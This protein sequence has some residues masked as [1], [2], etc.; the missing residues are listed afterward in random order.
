MVTIYDIAKKANVSPMTV[1]RV[2]NNSGKISEKTRE[3]VE[4]IIKELNYIPNNAARS[5]TL[6]QSKILSLLITDITN[7]FYTKVARGAEDKAKQMGYRLL[8]SNSDESL[9]KESEYVDMLISSGV[10][11]VLM[12]PAGDESKKNLKTLIKNKI[13]FVL[14]DRQVNGIDCDLVIGD[15][16][17]GTRQLLEHLIK[18]G[19]SKIALINGPAN[20]STAREREKAYFEIL[21]LAGIE[22]NKQLTSNISYRQNDSHKVVKN[23]ISLPESKRPTAI[24]AANNFIAINTIKSLRQLNVRVPEDMA[25]VCFDDP[26]PIP[27]FNPFLTLAAQPAYNFGYM[28]IQLL[29]ERVEGNGPAEKQRVI[30][31]PEIIIRNSSMRK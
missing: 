13:P 12:A 23:L 30:L 25:V 29:I 24:F 31:P 26:D 22:A 18:Q 3:K 1:S 28:G 16:Y 17:H 14:I 10:D 19:H 4:K 11:G 27:D 8:L 15:S 6:K 2:V 21:R 9:E 7:P 5:L 20:I